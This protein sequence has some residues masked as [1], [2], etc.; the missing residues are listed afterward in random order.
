MLDLEIVIMNSFNI[1]DKVE[2][3]QESVYTVTQ[4]WMFE[5]RNQVGEITEI[6]PIASGTYS[7]KF[8]GMPSSFYVYVDMIKL[9]GF[10]DD[11]Y[12]LI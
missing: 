12:E 7:V 11:D 3:D 8:P 10:R 4:K 6:N 2:I 5:F 9:S 1:G